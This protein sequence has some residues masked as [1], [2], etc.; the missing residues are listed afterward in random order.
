MIISQ[1]II[2]HAKRMYPKAISYKG[3]LTDKQ[4]QAIQEECDID[5]NTLAN[6]KKRYTIFYKGDLK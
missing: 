5:C 3:K 1:N 2:E 6:G 4:I